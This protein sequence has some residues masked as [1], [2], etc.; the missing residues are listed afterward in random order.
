MDLGYINEKL[1]H[2]VQRVQFEQV[3]LIGKTLGLAPG[4]QFLAKAQ[5]VTQTSPA[6]RAEIIKSID[7]SLAQLNKNSA[8]P[9]TKALINQL[10]EQ[11]NLL[12]NAAI[13][14]VNLDI[15]PQSVSRPNAATSP[16]PNL[17]TYTAQ[18][19]HSGQALLLQLTEASGLRM[20][21][22]LTQT[23]LDAVI[24]FLQSNGIDLAQTRITNPAMA[25]AL[26]VQ[27]SKLD[28][29]ALLETGAAGK[30]S[31]P[32]TEATRAAIT[33]T[34]RNLLPQKDSGQDVLASMPKIAQIIQQLP[35]A[36]RKEWLSSHIQDALKTLANQIRTSDQVTNPKLL[37]AAL[38]NNGQTFEN[39]LSQLPNSAQVSADSKANPLPGGKGTWNLPADVLKSGNAKLAGPVQTATATDK[40][41]AQD[42]KGALLSLSQQLLTE[43]N[44]TPLLLSADASRNSLSMTLPQL[45]GMFAN[46]QHGELNQKQ[47]RTQLIQLMHQYTLGSL[48]K[49]QLQQLHSLNHQ[50]SQPD[51]SQPNQSWQF[52]LPI[53]HGHEI[54]PL[55]IHLEQQW[56]EEQQDAQEKHNNRVRHWTVML[57]F[58]LPVVGKFY[59]QF[60]LLN[61][62]MSAKFWAERESTLTDAKQKLNVLTQHLESQG[63]K[64]TQMQFIPGLPPQPKMALGYSLV[65]IKT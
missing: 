57:N 32:I 27:I 46:R 15:N 5:S 31:P 54:H 48:A 44:K 63:I 6:E 33:E 7:A 8:A 60:A 26:A 10:T 16:L 34:L 61:D 9:A 58:D 30:K 53:R 3:A 25:K 17:L 41:F 39:K 51:V 4:S 45:L 56:I 20:L 12:Q 13:K 2:N 23:Q 52:E 43:L 50:L 38:A 24:K 35:V 49:I 64:V 19:V 28:L 1:L 29:S 18:P 22:P 62:A 14:L 11:K 59:A 65:D 47:M 42:L 21:Q 37:A 40:V 36:Q 55:Q